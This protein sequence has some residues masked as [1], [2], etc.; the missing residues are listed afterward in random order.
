M[1]ALQLPRLVNQ[2]IW[3]HLYVPNFVVLVIAGA[4]SLGPLTFGA[5]WAWL[6]WTLPI[7]LPM[8]VVG[9]LTVHGTPG[10]VVV[11]RWIVFVNRKLRKQTVYRH[12]PDSAEIHEL[13]REG[14]LTLPGRARNVRVLSAGAAALLHDQGTRTVSVIA[15]V[16]ASGFLSSS[17]ARQDELVNGLAGMHRAWT[18]RTGVKRFTQV[19]R[20]L[21]G[22]SR[23]AQRYVASH[24]RLPEGADPRLEDAMFEAFNLADARTRDHR[25]Q[26]VWTFDLVALAEQIRTA[27]GKEAGLA[28]VMKS[29]MDA[30]RHATLEAG[31]VAMRW[32]TP[33]EVRG[34]IRMQLDPAA[35]PFLQATEA[36]GRADEVMVPGTEAVM[37]LDEA[38]TFVQTD[39]GFHRTLWIV[40]WPQFQVRPGVLE[41]VITGSLP[42]GGVIRHTLAI[43][44][45]PV[46]IG[47]AMARI[48]DQKKGWEA[49]ERARRK[50][51]QITSESE[52]HDWE[53]LIEQEQQLIAGQGE[54]EVAAY[55]TLSATSLDDLD[56]A[57]SAMHT[58]LSNSGLES[59]VLFGQQAEALFATVVP[60][61]E[62]LG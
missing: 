32:L 2:G 54:F 57:S 56:R 34:L 30:L 15:E 18:L 28:R 36:E 21:T 45:T 61:G 35:A 3:G 51:G 49:R 40:Q 50:R 29:E 25:T 47:R 26:M 13:Q 16:G 52:K 37:A 14:F 41:K 33:G 42:D 31:F 8:A 20:T 17:D 6:L 59:H 5:G 44:E 7:W 19:E 60:T 27:G 39:S 24:L 46:P 43:V 58:H 1:I 62:G 48:R 38:R 55:L 11:W 12:R 23:A 10:P 22:S 9:F 53:L 4:L